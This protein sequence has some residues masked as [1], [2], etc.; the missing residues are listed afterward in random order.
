MRIIAR[1]FNRN[2]PS[3]KETAKSQC[4]HSIRA[5]C[6][7]WALWGRAIHCLNQAGKKDDNAIRLRE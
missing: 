1:A 4:F 6:H 5:L 3:S 7:V 2:C